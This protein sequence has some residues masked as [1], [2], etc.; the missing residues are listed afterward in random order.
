MTKIPLEK[1]LEMTKK[2]IAF[3][4]AKQL[5]EDEL[6]RRTYNSAIEDVAEAIDV[7]IKHNPQ[8]TLALRGLK[9]EVEAWM[10]LP[11]VMQ[12]G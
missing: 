12:N 7:Y 3:M 1:R 9:R 8:H 6:I 2:V 10:P 4:K 5:D 11:E